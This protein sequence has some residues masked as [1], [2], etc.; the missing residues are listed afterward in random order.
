MKTF[1]EYQA[2]ATRLPA[3]LRNNRDRVELA[4][5]GLQQEAGKMGSLFT[6]GFATG[7]FRLTREQVHEARNRLGDVL[8]HVALLCQEAGLTMQDVAEHSLAQL[9]ARREQFDPGQR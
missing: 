2:L 5:L 9:E 7:R 6:A 3:A 8:W 4:L 1:D